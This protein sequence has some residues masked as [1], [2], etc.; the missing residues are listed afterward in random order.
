MEI[1]ITN[2]I[3]KIKAAYNFT[4]ATL[5]EALGVSYRTVEGWRQG[6]PISKPA[7]RLLELFEKGKIPAEE[8]N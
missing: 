4:D 8:A 2:R 6:R 5:A 1:S 7:E 3:S